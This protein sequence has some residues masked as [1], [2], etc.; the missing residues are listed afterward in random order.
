MARNGSG[1]YNLVTNSWYPPVNG[2]SATATDWQTFIEDVAAALTQSIAADGQT[3]ITGNLSMG[4]NILTGLGAGSATGHSLRWQQLFDQGT[5]ADLAS[6]ATTDIGSQN[7]NFLRITGTTTITSFGTTYRGPRFV[8]FAGAL[9]LTHNASTLILPT[10]ANI[11]TAAGDRAIIAP[12]A[13]AGTADGWQVVAYQ[14]ADGSALVGGP[15][16]NTT[17]AATAKIAGRVTSGAGNTEELPIINYAN[18]GR[19]QLVLSGGNLVLNPFNGNS[20]VING[21]TYQV[22]SAGVS[23]SASGLTPSTL[24]Y[25]YAY[26]NSGTMTLEASTTGHSTDTTTGV[27][28]KTGDATRTLVGM[29]R[30]VTGPAFADSQ[31]QRLVRSWFNDSG[32]FASQILSS[33]ASTTSLTFTELTTALRSDFLCWANERIRIW[34]QGNIQNST[35]GQRCA[36]SPR[37]DGGSTLSTNGAFTSGNAGSVNQGFF[38]MD[39]GTASEGY[40]YSSVFVFVTSGTGTWEGGLS[41]EFMTLKVA[42]EGRP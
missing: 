33:D 20:L 38:V 31:T 14:K 10:G 24:Y 11:T 27:E 37:Y 5:E 30:P 22:P 4:G 3:P 25:I 12:K 7:T 17:F 19:C 16:T 41:G 35:A 39:E 9:T 42:C 34:A 21:L 26:M 18:H 15:I 23:L 13:T 8:R 40:H 29:A 32:V 2:V 1:T 36:T 6:A 28:I